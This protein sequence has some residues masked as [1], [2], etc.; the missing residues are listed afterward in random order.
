VVATGLSNPL[1]F[2]Q[3]PVFANVAYVVEQ[4]GLVKIIRDGQLQPDIFADLR[5]LTT[6]SGERGLLG[7]AFSPD[8]QSGRVFFNY[9]NLIGDTVISRYTRMAGSPQQIDAAARFDLQ[10]PGGERFIRQPFANHNGG[11]LA[12]GP[13]GYLYIAL[14]DGGSANDP[15]N[16][17]Q[18]PN[19]LLGK[20]LRIDV[21]VADVDPIGYRIPNDNPF[22]DGVPITAL[23]EIW[24]FGLRNPWRYSF[25]D[26]G[27]GA[28]GAL[29]IGD[30]GQNSREE[31]DQEPAGLGGRNYGWRIREGFIAT[32]GV[33]VT[34]PAYNPLTDPL[35]DYDRNAGQ[36]VIGGYVYRGTALAP[37]FRGR[38]FFADF[39]TS[40][41]WSI[42]L[43]PTP[44][45][46]GGALPTCSPMV[47]ANRCQPSAWPDLV[48]HT[49]ELGG[50]LGNLSSFGRDAVGELYLLTYS[51]RVLKLVPPSAG[52]IAPPRA[53][54]DR[55]TQQE[56]APRK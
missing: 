33:P 36:T 39:I 28:T 22:L 44:A 37:Y 35:I 3:D 24:A 5:A 17:A 19:T 30:V 51:G 53:A 47:P 50:S 45:P 4:G 54:D 27:Q 31:I 2:V 25:D 40:R 7:M 14:G 29:L 15:Q 13:D 11:N 10:W 38:Y 18:D 20:M 52:S 16:N 42:R 26:F 23:G 43:T 34:T 9:T 56:P 1:G 12:F 48:D 55:R 32:P 6:S 46:F 49:S 21:A 8:L 41:V